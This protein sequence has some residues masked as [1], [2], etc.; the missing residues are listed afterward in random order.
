MAVVGADCRLM[1]ATPEAIAW[2]DELES[3]YR[4]PDPV[5]GIDVPSEVDGRDAGRARAEP[6]RPAHGRAAASGC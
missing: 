1:S 6:P 5:F 4:V 2:F 3:A